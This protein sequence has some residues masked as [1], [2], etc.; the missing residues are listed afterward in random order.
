MSDASELLWEFDAATD[1]EAMSVQLLD[2][3][4]RARRGDSA[5]V[6]EVLARD[7]RFW[8]RYRCLR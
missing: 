7:L 4:A 5:G 8:R 3:M 1:E 6:R 2:A